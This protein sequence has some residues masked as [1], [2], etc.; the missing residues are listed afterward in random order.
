MIDDLNVIVDKVRSMQVTLVCAPE[1]YDALKAA[2]LSKPELDG[3]WNLI[4]SPL[5][6]DQTAVY[7]VSPGAFDDFLPRQGSDLYEKDGWRHSTRPRPA[8]A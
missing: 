8:A 6:T 5:I 3:T 1:R 2:L 7:S 4:A